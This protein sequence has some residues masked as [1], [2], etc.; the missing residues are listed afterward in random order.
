MTDLIAGYL[1][2]AGFVIIYI[3]KQLTVFVLQRILCSAVSLAYR[4]MMT[5]AA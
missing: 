1:I 2:H 5:L 4:S 3:Q